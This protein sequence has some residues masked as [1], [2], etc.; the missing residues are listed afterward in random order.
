MIIICWNNLI[1]RN[2]V[3]LCAIYQLLCYHQPPLTEQGHRS[4]LLQ[5]FMDQTV[6]NYC[7]SPPLSTLLKKTITSTHLFEMIWDAN[8]YYLCHFPYREG[9][10]E[11][12][13][14]GVTGRQDSRRGFAMKQS[15]LM[16][17]DWVQGNGTQTGRHRNTES[18]EEWLDL[19]CKWYITAT[20]T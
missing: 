11:Y 18:T 3:N 10:I 2:L 5:T 8:A 19:N 9:C 17:S 12:N 13:R 4:V 1:A 16:N 15:L 6:D 14:R 7:G 20:L